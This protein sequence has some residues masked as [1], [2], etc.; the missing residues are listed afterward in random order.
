M[1]INSG[2]NASHNGF[3][4]LLSLYG[5]FTLTFLFVCSSDEPPRLLYRLIYNLPLPIPHPA[6]CHTD[7]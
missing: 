7:V 4:E 5:Y 6:T 2:S 1:S 3:M